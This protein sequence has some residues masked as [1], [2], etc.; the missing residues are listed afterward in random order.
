MKVCVSPETLKVVQGHPT[1]YGSPAFRHSQCEAQMFRT[2]RN[3]L[4]ME[5]AKTWNFCS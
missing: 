1:V 2:N 4:L 5:V 3:V